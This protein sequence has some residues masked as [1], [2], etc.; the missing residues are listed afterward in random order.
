MANKAF[1]AKNG[2]TVNTASII[3]SELSGTLTPTTAGQIL[4]TDGTGQMGTRTEAQIKSDIGAGVVETVTAG[5]GLTGGGT[6][7]SVTVTMGTPTT[8]TVST[9]DTVGAETHAHAI[10]T[11]S[12]VTGGTASILASDGT[13]KLQVATINATSVQIGGTAVSSTAAELNLLDGSAKSTSSITLADADGFIVIDGTTTKQIPAS[14][15]A[16]YVSGAGAADFSADIL[17]N[18]SGTINLGSATKE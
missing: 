14:D 5:N 1:V 13:G 17:P 2:L 6:S 12:D 18:A 11:S 7:S 9:T 4:I 3:M 16:T 8:L 10:T 15:I